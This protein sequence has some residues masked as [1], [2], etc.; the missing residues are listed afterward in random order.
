[1]MPRGNTFIEFN[2]FENAYGVMADETNGF[3]AFT[4][5]HVLAAI[6]KN[7]LVFVVLRSILGFSPPEL[8]HLASAGD[9]I[10]VTQGFTR[11]L[12]QRARN[13]TTLVP[14]TG[15]AK[16]RL[17]ALVRRACETISAGIPPSSSPKGIHRLAQ[18]RHVKSGFEPFFCFWVRKSFVFNERMLSD[19]NSDYASS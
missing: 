3:S 15:T 17:E 18:L 4:A 19:E 8:A 1:M 11:T 7:P 16:E 14:K 9:T 5:E 2:E 13:H 12:D 10:R 6:R